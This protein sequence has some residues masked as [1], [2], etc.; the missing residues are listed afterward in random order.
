M[1]HLALMHV[2]LGVDVPDRKNQ[3]LETRAIKATRMATFPLNLQKDSKAAAGG[4]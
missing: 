4:I 2:V 1:L 3:R